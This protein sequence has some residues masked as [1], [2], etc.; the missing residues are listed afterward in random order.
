VH[1]IYYALPDQAWRI[2]QMMAL[3]ADLFSDQPWT[4][5]HERKQGSLLGYTPEQ[6]DAWSLWRAREKRNV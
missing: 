5:A 1:Y 3:Q 2:P 6:N 4:E